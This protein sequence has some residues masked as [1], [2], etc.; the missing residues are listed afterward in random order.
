MKAA[1]IRFIKS[2]RESQF[3]FRHKD[4]I[5]KT[6]E[7]IKDEYAKIEGAI[8]MPDNPHVLERAGQARLDF[9][10]LLLQLEKQLSRYLDFRNLK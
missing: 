8:T 5:Y 4:G 6:L 3:L 7:N 1:G 10:P 9:E 2:F